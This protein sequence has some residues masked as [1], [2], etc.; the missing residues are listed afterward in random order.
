MRDLL[1]CERRAARIS[2]ECVGCEKLSDVEKLEKAAK[3]TNSAFQQTFSIGSYVAKE[4][5]RNFLAMG[6]SQIA[7]LGLEGMIK[8][9]SSSYEKNVRQGIE[10]AV[11]NLLGRKWWRKR[12]AL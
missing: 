2:G 4:M 9:I 11:N 7:I 8:T 6:I 12:M 5:G 10:N 3:M 1:W